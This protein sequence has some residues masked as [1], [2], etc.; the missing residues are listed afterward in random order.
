MTRR[1]FVVT[2]GARGV[3]QAIALRLSQHGHVVVPDRV[4]PLDWRNPAVRLVTGGASD[5][6]RQGRGGSASGGGRRAH[7]LVNNA[8][9]FPESDVDHP[10]P[11]HLGPKHFPPDRVKL[12][13][14]L[15][16]VQPL[17]RPDIQ[18]E[19]LLYLALPYLAHT[20][21]PR[22]PVQASARVKTTCTTP[23]G[24]ATDSML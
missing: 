20:P 11:K 5:P 14:R 7:R 19:L 4:T 16:R 2:G 8:A 23:L 6:C 17:D 18:V 15:L 12:T 9:V 3:G 10:D 1:S 22:S 21:R 13:G 24:E